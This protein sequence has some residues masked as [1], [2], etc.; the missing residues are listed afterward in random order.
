MSD[1]AIIPYCRRN[2]LSST[3]SIRK[4]TKTPPGSRTTQTGIFMF[5]RTTSRRGQAG[6]GG[7]LPL[8]GRTRN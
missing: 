2:E 5:G 1:K 4:R 7:I 8:A 6:E 3:A